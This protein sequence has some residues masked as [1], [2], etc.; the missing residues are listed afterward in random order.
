M[1]H[2]NPPLAYGHRHREKAFRYGVGMGRVISKHGYALPFRV[3][4]IFRPLAGA[5]LSLFTLRFS[6]AAYHLS[7]GMGRLAGLWS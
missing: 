1:Y 7:I 3:R 4:V 2:L 6:K 5:V